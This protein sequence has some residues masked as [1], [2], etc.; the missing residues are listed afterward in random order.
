MKRKQKKS[1]IDNDFNLHRTVITFPNTAWVPCITNETQSIQNPGPSTASHQLKTILNP[2]KIDTD[3]F[4]I[5]ILV[6]CLRDKFCKH[7]SLNVATQPP[8]RWK[9]QTNT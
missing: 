2:E 6:F 1:Q 9:S 7:E 3:T 4:N 8:I 5:G